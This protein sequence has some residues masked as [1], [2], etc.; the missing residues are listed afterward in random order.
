MKKST[1]RWIP[2]IAVP[3]VVVAAAVAVPQMAN[4]DAQLPTKSAAQIAQLALTSDGASFSGTVVESA[5]LGLP[6]IPTSD[7]GGSSGSQSSATSALGMLSGTHTARVFS[8]GKTKQ[9]IQVISDL[10]ETDVYRN[11]ADVW[12]YDSSKNQAVHATLPARSS[13]SATPGAMSVPTT[14]AAAAARVLKRIGPATTITTDKNVT[15]AGRG[16]YQIELAPKASGSLVKSVTLAVD[17]TTGTPLKVTVS[18]VGQKSPAI[19]IG[20]SKIDFSTPSSSVFEYTPSSTTKVKTVT[21][22]KRSASSNEKHSDA[23]KRG[24]A[25]AAPTVIGTGWNSIVGATVPAKALESLTK[26]SSSA[27]LGDVLTTVPGGR[28]V[29]TSLF[30]AYLTTDGHV[31]VGAVSASALQAAVAAAA[32]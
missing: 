6:S 8:A 7:L 14:P 4:A 11:G 22:P 24:V 2:A 26:S 9:R 30:S 12:T 15:V 29:Q 23:V 20:F 1:A 18:A 27:L 13:R 21:V 17:A 10:A 3:V 5:D 28:I 25:T 31:Y 16:A 32:K 19:S